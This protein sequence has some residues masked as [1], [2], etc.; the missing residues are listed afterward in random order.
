M[1]Y[2]WRCGVWLGEEKGVGGSEWE[3]LVDLPSNDIIN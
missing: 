3:S 1:V 2:G